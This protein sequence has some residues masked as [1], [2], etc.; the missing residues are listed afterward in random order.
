M[1]FS[2]LVASAVSGCF[3]RLFVHPLDT[4]RSRLMVSTAT[5]ATFAVVARHLIQTDGFNG[6]YR[7]FGVSICMQAPATATFLSSYDWSKSQLSTVSSLPSSSPAI[8]LASGLVA[9]TVSAVF[10][11]PMEVIKQR[12]QVR[13]GTMGAAWS[14]AIAKDL[15]KHEGPRAF[16]KG[17][18]L[19][20]GVFGP[21]SMIYFVVYERLKSIAMRIRNDQTVTQLPTHTVAACAGTAGGFAAACTTPLDVIKTRLQTQGDRHSQTQ[22]SGFRAAPA[23][24]GTWHAAQSIWA[25]ERFRGFFR[26]IS[27]RVLWI[28][29]STAITMSTFEFLKFYFKLSP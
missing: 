14:S 18:A 13:S 10:W 20:V 3:A 12:A 24:S 8:H 1:G 21:Y 6:L 27:A 15:L 9:E 23:Y 25:K 22:V 5:N 4:I 2:L 17:Y 19:T 7:G 26:G 16:F 29:P 28:M 11:V